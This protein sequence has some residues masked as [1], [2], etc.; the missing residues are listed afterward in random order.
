MKTQL[1][2]YHNDESE[3]KNTRC[4]ERDPL[5]RKYSHP[6]SAI[7]SAHSTRTFR[8]DGLREINANES[9]DLMRVRLVRDLFLA[10]S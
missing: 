7:F 8:P 3:N 9:T 2:T 1:R 5:K 4:H 10:R 6:H